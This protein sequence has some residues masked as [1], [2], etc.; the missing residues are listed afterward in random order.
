MTTSLHLLEPSATASWAPFAGVRPV[1]ELRA[2]A[3][4]VHE[5]WELVTTLP[6]ASILSDAVPGFADTGNIPVHPTATPV[7]GPALVVRADFAPDLDAR[8]GSA[9]AGTL[10]DP[11]GTPVGWWVPRGSTWGGAGQTPEE[12]TATVPG[13]RLTGAAS[14][15]D[16]LEQRLGADCLQL[17]D[18][19][20]VPAGTIVL[21]DPTLLAASDAVIEPGVVLDL[22]GGPIVLEE[23]V[24]VRSGTRLEGP[25]HVH[26]DTLLLGG[27]IRH[28]VIGPSC[29]VHGEVASSIFTGF[30][31]KAHDGFLGHSVLGQWVNLGAGTITSNLKNTYGEISLALP[32]GPVRTGRM[33]LGSLIGDHAKTAIGTLLATGTIV[34]AGAS[35][36]GPPPVPRHVPAFSWGTTGAERVTLEGFLRVAARVMPRRGVELTPAREEALR[37]LHARLTRLPP[38]PAR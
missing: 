34:G 38:G 22:R 36:H 10:V 9:L 3:L 29:R 23:G 14:L 33:F 8:M 21:G 18:P 25:L 4:L 13:M 12:P 32:G 19:S 11:R 16:M 17:L 24:V 31:N 7:P 20:P 1:S 30:A 26:V 28:S 2:G 6:T 37:Q 35:V 27:S 5:R 15:L